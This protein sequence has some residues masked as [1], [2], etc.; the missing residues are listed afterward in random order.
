YERIGEPSIQVV[1]PVSNP[2]KTFDKVD[3]VTEIQAEEVDATATDAPRLLLIGSCDLT[4]VASYCSP[5]R[6]E[7]VNG[8]KNGIMTRYDD[9]GFILGDEAKVKA[10]KA[11]EKIPSWDKTDFASFHERLASSDVLIV[12]LS[13]AMKGA[14]LLTDDGVVVRVHPEGLG[15]YIDAHPWANFLK[16]ATLYEA[17]RPQRVDMLKRS[18]D[19]L[20]VSAMEAKQKFLLGANTRDVNGALSPENH[21]IL[22]LY[23][24]ACAAFCQANANWQFVSINDVVAYGELIDD[25]HYTR[26]GYLEIANYIKEKIR[27]TEVIAEQRKPA[28]PVGTNL[29]DMIRSG[30][31]VSRLHLFGAKTGALSHVK[32]VIKLTP[33]SAVFRRRFIGPKKNSRAP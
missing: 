17:S 26:L 6:A 14:H 1:G 30:R 19:F 2:I 29:V 21:E 22:T 33:L 28:E 12:S 18:L 13:A 20:N 16:S 11:L 7:Y 24:E 5:N 25:R 10:S 23:N 9:F 8:V 27:S 15:S 32:R 3:W 4:A 31:M